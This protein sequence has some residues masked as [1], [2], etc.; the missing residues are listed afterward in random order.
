MD[1]CLQFLKSPQT[2]QFMEFCVRTLRKTGS[3]ITFLTQG[4]DEILSSPI[5]SAIL[6]N[7]ANKIILMQKGDIDIISD[8]LKLN[9]QEV[10]LIQGLSQ[11]KGEFSEAFVIH[12]DK[13][14]ILKIAP[15]SEEYWI[16]TTDAKD[17]DFFQKYRNENKEKPLLL[18]IDELSQ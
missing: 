8:T 6:N 16:S 5:S 7:T 4:L 3:G 18:L 12:G 1:E 15:T 11:K 14:F 13:R 9:D 2:I 17:N 10:A